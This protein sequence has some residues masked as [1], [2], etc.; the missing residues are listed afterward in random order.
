VT[1]SWGLC[2]SSE[3]PPAGSLPLTGTL[4]TIQAVQSGTPLVHNGPAKPICIARYAFAR[5]PQILSSGREGLQQGYA[6]HVE[7]DADEGEDLWRSRYQRPGS[8]KR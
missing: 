6:A 5:G 4:T 1:K 8:G 3:A 2:A 7:E